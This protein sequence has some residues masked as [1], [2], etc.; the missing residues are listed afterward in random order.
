MK[1]RVVDTGIADAATNMAIDEAIMQ[2]HAAGDVPPTLRFYGWQPSAVSIGYFQQATEDIDFAACAASGVSVVR[3]L[4]GGRA[5]LHDREL[6]YSIVI[7]DDDPSIPAA[8]IASYGFFSTGLLAGLQS[9]GINARMSISRQA[10]GQSRRKQESSA[11]CFDT[12][13]NYEI[14]YDNRKLVGSAQVRKHGVILQHGSILLH[15]SARKAAAVLKFSSP[16]SRIAMEKKL[17]MRVASVEEIIRH[18]ITRDEMAASITTA[19]GP[20]LGIELQE[21]GLTAGEEATGSRLAR[22]KYNQSSWTLMR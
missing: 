11:A 14:T 20:A 8:I 16:E 18:G 6:T 10:Y 22:D 13:S 15:F 4:T 2:A 7:R 21:Q 3:R 19:L 17:E 1:W 9:L 12:S 5:V